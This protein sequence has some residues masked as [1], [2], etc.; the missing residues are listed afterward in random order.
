[1]VTQTFTTA[2]EQY[3]IMLNNYSS[4]LEK[5]NQQ[6]GLWSNPYGIMIMTL[7][8]LIALLAIVVAFI[9]Y[10][11]GKDYKEKL[12][13]DRKQQNKNFD[14]FLASQKSIIEEREVK[15]SEVEEKID[16]LLEEY[17]KKLKVSSKEQKIEI[18]R[19]I[20]DL[21]EQKV[22]LG[23]MI[24]PLTVSPNRLD[25]TCAFTSA[26]TMSDIYK[27]LGLK[28]MHHVCNKCGFG[29]FVENNL[30]TLGVIGR[31]VTCPKCGSVD[32]I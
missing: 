32:Y 20:K 6:L 7:T 12:E 23:G 3:Q 1:M 28:N 21:K 8:V 2:P 5:T 16:K 11:Q 27:N 31:T 22:T 19:A 14:D 24:G 18:E 29:F 15:A 25:T 4:I 26:P 13:D 10:R 9:I 17:E 30:A